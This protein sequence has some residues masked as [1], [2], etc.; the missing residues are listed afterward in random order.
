[1][2]AAVLAID[3]GTG[4]PKVAL[5][6]RD[7]V[8]LAREFEP[9]TVQLHPGGG[10]SQRPADW[11]TAITTASR[12]LLAGREVDVR[13]VA[14]TGQWA[15]TV[16]L[17]EAGEPLGDAVIWLD[18]RG[19]EHARRL[20]GGRIRVAG[21]DPRK[22]ARWL[23]RT[24][25][26]PSL[27]GRDPLGHILWLRAE[28][29][30]MYAAARCFLEPVDWLGYKLTGRA[31][32]TAV[33]ATLHWVT[34][35]RDAN[36]IRYDHDL[37]AL[38][39]L[40]RDQLPELLP[41]NATLGPLTE[42]AR[43]QLGLPDVRRSPSPET[44]GP[45]T[46]GRRAFPETV[47][48]HGPHAPPVVAGT[49]DTMSAAIGSG[50]TK[51]HAAH[52]YVGTSAWLSCHVP[53]KRTDPLHNVASLPSAIPGRYLVSTEQQTAGV[54]FERLRDLL[55]EDF[56]ELERLAASARPGSGGVVFTPWLNGE[57]TPVDDELVRGGLHN[58]TLATTRAEI[59]RAVLEGVALNARW[60]HRVVERFCRRR[61]DPIAFV[62]GGALSPLWAQIMADVLGRTIHRVEDPVSANVRGA[63]LL[64]WLALGELRAEEL[65]GR[66]AIAEVHVPLHDYDELYK[67]FRAIY[68]SSRRTRRRL[69]AVRDT[70]P[71]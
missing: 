23:R 25:G 40:H 34:D 47:P 56:A 41:P 44:L 64:G 17:D 13:A 16:A 62:G 50:A 31:A 10:A 60:M 61:L 19:A 32:T 35:T 4:G 45:E 29:P 42:S 54:A 36:N 20:A 57:R 24:G 7:G 69:A 39:G 53:Y 49:P 3:L 33:T 68:R 6:D 65:H 51:D 58:L 59:A 26:A 48:G 46:G 66:A 67:A 55:G 1:V 14:V 22:L 70:D 2:T 63:G 28:R 15:G 52:L 30:E 5:V 8:V 12:R 27:A 11:W 43:A 9:N 21:Y 38:A 37:I 71:R 18:T